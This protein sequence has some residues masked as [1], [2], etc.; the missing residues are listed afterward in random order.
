MKAPNLA[1]IVETDIP[2]ESRQLD[3]A[4][5]A[6]LRTDVLQPI[7]KLQSDGYIEWFSFLLHPARLVKGRAPNDETWV[8]H[9]RLEPSSDLNVDKLINLLPEHFRDPQHVDLAEISGL[10]GALLMDSDWAQAWRIVG[11]S[12]EWVLCLLE[13]HED[14]LPPEQI[15]QFLHY[16]TNALCLGGTC[17]HTSKQIHF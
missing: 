3:A 10:N 1:R 12:A 11:E 15:F 16:M 9:L 17:V 13:A 14:E 6:Q 7:R 8:F 2:V 4:Y 5:L